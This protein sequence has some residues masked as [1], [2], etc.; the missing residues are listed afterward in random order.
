MNMRRIA[1]IGGAAAGLLVAGALAYSWMWSEMTDV[2]PV[3]LDQPGG[4]AIEGYD[5]VAYFTEGEAVQGSGEFSLEYRGAQWLFA[6]EENRQLFEAEPAKYAPAYGG[7]CA[8]GVSSGYGVRGDPEQWSIVE[9]AALSELQRRCQSR[10]EQGC[11]RL[12][13]QVRGRVAQ[14]V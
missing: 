6:S 14:A 7:H 2:S 3:Y 12:P 1:V 8:Y 5:A 9:G 4:S 10:V 13:G 11:S